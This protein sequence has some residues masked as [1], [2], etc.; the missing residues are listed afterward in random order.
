MDLIRFKYAVRQASALILCTLS[1]TAFA[2]AS[3]YDQ[4]NL[5]SDGFVAADNTDPN[6]INPWG[7]AFGTTD[8]VWIANNG[9]GTSTIYNGLGNPFSLIVKIPTPHIN[10]TAISAPTG[11]VFNNSSGW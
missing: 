7:I 3:L 5:V 9:S 4:H 8:P 11:I 10:P 6:L 1:I 2:Q